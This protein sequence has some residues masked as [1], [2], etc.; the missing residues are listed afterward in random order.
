M[1]SA[2]SF[3]SYMARENVVSS[4]LALFVVSVFAAL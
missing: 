3:E 4:S 1:G 2:I